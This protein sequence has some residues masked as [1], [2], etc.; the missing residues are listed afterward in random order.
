MC[1]NAQL[2]LVWLIFIL[3]VHGKS[4]KPMIGCGRLITRTS[5]K[6]VCFTTAQHARAM[7]QQWQHRLHLS[8]LQLIDKTQAASKI[9]NYRSFHATH[10]WWNYDKKIT[11]KESLMIIQ[12]LSKNKVTVYPNKSLCQFHRL[13][14]SKLRKSYQTFVVPTAWL[15]THHP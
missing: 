11:S 3:G 12:I 5:A 14:L 1:L 4:T 6:H 9:D 7:D 10:M 15:A 2:W 8:C 13:N